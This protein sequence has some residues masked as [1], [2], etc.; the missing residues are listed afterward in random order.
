VVG[1]A[2]LVLLFI[3]DALFG[4]SDS[5]FNGSL[6]E[7]AT[8]APR[9]RTPTTEQQFTHDARP[10]DRVREV[11]AQFVPNDSRRGKRFA[12]GVTVTR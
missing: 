6:Y 1:S 9:E 8:Y 7:S 11:F 5:R 2:L 3:S 12:P 10:V 4:E